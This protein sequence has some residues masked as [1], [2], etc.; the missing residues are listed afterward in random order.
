MSDPGREGETG[1]VPELL[2]PAGSMESLRAAIAAGADAVYLGGKRFGAR[3]Y[4]PNFSP[5][6][7]QEAVGEV[8]LHGVRV[9]VTVNTLIRECELADALSYLRDLSGMGVDGVILQDTGLLSLARRSLP[10]LPLHASTQATIATPAGV[11]WAKRAGYSRV[12]LPRELLPSQLD[13]ILAIPRDGRPEIEV[14]VHG[15]LCYSYSG[16]CLLSSLIGGRSGNRG[17]C[18]QPCRKPY[19]LVQVTGGKGGAGPEI[20]VIPTQERFL[21][22]T[23]D[24]CCYRGLPDIARRDI[25]ALKIEGRMR[26]ATY[27]AIVVRAYR[28]ALDALLAKK[29]HVF[30]EDEEAMA[31][32][33]S[34]GFTRG[35]ILGETSVMGRSAP[36][37]RGLFLGVVRSIGEGDGLL[38]SAV[39]QTVPAPG[40][41]ILVTGP[42][43]AIR[44]GQ[45][46]KSRC[47]REKGDLLLP[48]PARGARP[49]DSVFLTRSRV[50]EE[51]MRSILT[52][53]R[54]RRHVP[55]SLWLRVHP[56]EPV[57]WRATLVHPRRGRITLSG[58]ADAVPHAARTRPL[59]PEMIR[60]R[61]E[62]A[63]ES[64]FDLSDISVETSGD[65]FLPISS[66]NGVKREILDRIKEEWIRSFCPAPPERERAH[67][68]VAAVIR[69]RGLL[70]ASAPPSPVRR[71]PVILSVY[72][73]TLGELEEAC[74]QKAPLICFEPTASEGDPDCIPDVREGSARCRAA[75]VFFAWMWPRVAPPAFVREMLEKL[76]RL[77]REGIGRVMVSEAGLAEAICGHVPGMVVYGGSGLNITNAEAALFFHPPVSR[78]TL[79]HEIP[80]DDIPLLVSRA[81]KMCPSISFEVVCQGTIE[82]MVSKNRLL[83]DLLGNTPVNFQD[84]SFG[85]EDGTGRIFPVYEDR[86]GRTRILNAVE[87]TLIDYV[88]FL[89]AAGVRSLAIDARRR[90]VAYVREVVPAYGEAIALACSGIHDPERMACLKERIRHVAWGGLTAGH[91]L[92]SSL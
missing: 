75:G 90:G 61:F 91:F 8:H 52:A 48:V 63:G 40:D 68:A 25:A 41:G 27:V 19:R 79:S 80:R 5:G 58:S 35:Y 78:F 69:E 11:A 17:M 60:A 2:A 23:R 10:D 53:G 71:E 33:F 89:V 31:I 7:M 45:L 49:G 36:G 62:K 6:E 18:A 20:R 43:G 54:V 30:L 38:V 42:G 56:G 77:F 88:P 83:S 87:T 59:S 16:Q 28:R 55:V 64:P 46:L 21:L 65:S 15:A 12:I 76:P 3:H 67:A 73:A 4:A 92:R 22:S 74:R 81:E 29:N 51:R 9:Y 85:L 37:N 82:A 1:R 13:E 72:C 50:L 24:L 86:L 32:A 70:P 84:G 39:T 66:L 44:A 57:A 34:R 26:S 14:F 47:R